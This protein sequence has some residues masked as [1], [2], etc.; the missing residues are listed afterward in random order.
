MDEGNA[1]IGA[2]I[3]VILSVPLWAIIIAAVWLGY[4]MLWLV[5]P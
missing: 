5:L 2:A 4:R 3:G 1:L